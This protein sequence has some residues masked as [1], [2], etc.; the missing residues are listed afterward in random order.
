MS[1][2]YMK[3]STSTR[4]HWLVKN[5]RCPSCRGMRLDMTSGRKLPPASLCANCGWYGWPD[6]G[7]LAYPVPPKTPTPSAN[8]PQKRDS[9]SETGVYTEPTYKTKFCSEC[10]ESECPTPDHCDPNDPAGVSD[11][12][13]SNERVT[14]G[15]SH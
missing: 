11:E 15:Q 1:S 12:G 5:A 2:S 7:E 6:L 3:R 8:E 9:G 10:G 14:H 4:L 13:F